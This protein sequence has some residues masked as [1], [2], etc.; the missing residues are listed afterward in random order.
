MSPGDKKGH[1]FSEIALRNRIGEILIGSVE[2][3]IK[4]WRPGP[5]DFCETCKNMF[6]EKI[7]TFFVK[8]TIK[9]AQNE[10]REKLL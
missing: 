10:F 1:N 4:F 6:P 8:L 5:R 2:K 9:K 7:S 3:N